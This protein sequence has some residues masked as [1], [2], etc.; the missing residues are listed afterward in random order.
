MSGIVIYSGVGECR[1][2]SCR[3]KIERQKNKKQNPNMEHDNNYKN[4]IWYLPIG[5]FQLPVKWSPIL[6]DV[7]TENTKP[8]YI[9]KLAFRRL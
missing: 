8:L 9:T 3:A 4:E 2:E 1:S 5:N 7:K 6:R